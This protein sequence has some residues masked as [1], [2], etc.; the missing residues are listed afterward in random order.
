MTPSTLII[1]SEL[2]TFW[3]SVKLWTHACRIPTIFYR[4]IAQNKKPQKNESLQ[5]M[6]QT[7]S[8]FICP[9]TKQSCSAASKGKNAQ[10]LLMSEVK[11]F[12]GNDYFA[13]LSSPNSEL[14]DI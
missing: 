1:P 13:E 10:I 9:S 7:F 12:D 3:S 4:I 2:L 14:A 6:A 8:C 11:N 5:T